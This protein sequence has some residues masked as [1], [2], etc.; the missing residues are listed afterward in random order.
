MVIMFF[1]C[2]EVFFADVGLVIRFAFHYVV[3]SRLALYSEI[4]LATTHPEVALHAPLGA[5]RVTHSP[6]LGS[7]LINAP[8]EDDHRVV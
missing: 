2:S 8:A 5:V 4:V 3:G 7:L 1:I 6:E